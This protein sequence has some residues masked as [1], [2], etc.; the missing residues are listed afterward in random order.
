[1]KKRAILAVSAIVTVSLAAGSTPAF[2]AEDYP[3]WAD[4]EAAKHDEKAKKAEIAKIEDFIAGLE[5]TNSGLAK[6]ALVVN[7][8]YN[9]A[10]G[11]LDDAVAAS[12]ALKKKADAASAAAATSR[13]QVGQ[14][15]AQ[16]ARTGGSDVTLNLL[17]D[18]S[19]ATDYLYALGQLDGVTA[20]TAAIYARAITA[21]N[22]STSLQKQAAVAEKVRTS[23]AAAAKSDLAEAQAASAAAKKSLSAQQAKAKQLYDQLASLKGTTSATEKA[24][25]AGI[26]WEKAQAAVKTPPPPPPGPPVNPPPAAPSGS[27]VTGAIAFAEAQLGEAYALG[28]SGP[29]T[30]DCSGLTK[31][32]YAS[33]GVYIGTHSATNQYS[34]MAAEGRLLPLADLQAGDLLF[35]SSGGSTTATKYHTAL[36][37]GAGQMIEAPYPGS[38][39]RIKPVRYGDLVPYAGRPTP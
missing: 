3:T 5:A 12:D 18:S 27:G 30:W 26:A 36:Y 33:V 22:E 31:A 23:K 20:H 6:D 25:E 7:E 24:Y 37:I 35:Y 9:E 17:V 16:L 14:L 34:T 19:N 39:V 10:K 8:E 21:R 11:A 38:V 29:D 13:Q 2:A 28:G 4:V 1:M 15:A 32:A